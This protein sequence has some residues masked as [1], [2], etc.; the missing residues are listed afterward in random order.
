M[1]DCRGA[2]LTSGIVTKLP[3]GVRWLGDGTSTT[4]LNF[5]HSDVA[6]SDR[7]D[8]DIVVYDFDR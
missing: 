6:A 2:W 1:A 4:S 8:A 3:E 5:W 7:E